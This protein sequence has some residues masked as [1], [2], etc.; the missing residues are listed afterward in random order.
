MWFLVLFQDLNLFQPEPGTCALSFESENKENSSLS[1]YTLEKLT[2]EN[3]QLIYAPLIFNISMENTSHVSMSGTSCKITAFR[4]LSWVLYGSQKHLF[5]VH[6]LFETTAKLSSSFGN[7]YD[8]VQSGP[9]RSTDTIRWFI[10]CSPE[11]WSCLVNQW[12]RQAD[13][14]WVLGW[15]SWSQ[16]KQVYRRQVNQAMLKG[17]KRILPQ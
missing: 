17:Q 15:Q 6:Q 4:N 9:K 16:R 12:G 7:C 3:I 8:V 5:L 13:R 10:G 2:F 11:L 14:D 1:V